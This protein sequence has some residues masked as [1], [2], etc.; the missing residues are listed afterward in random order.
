MSIDKIRQVIQCIVHA[1]QT[2][3]IIIDSPTLQPPE[4]TKKIENSLVISPMPGKLQIKSKK[5]TQISFGLSVWCT[6]SKTDRLIIDQMKTNAASDVNCSSIE[7]PIVC[8]PY[9]VLTC[10]Y[11][12]WRCQYFETM[13][14]YLQSTNIFFA[15]PSLTPIEDE[16]LWN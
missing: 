14:N 9:L 2:F 8:Q 10:N 13:D 4:N 5:Q 6:E 3:R 11:W 1:P 12:V 15:P 16:F 7:L